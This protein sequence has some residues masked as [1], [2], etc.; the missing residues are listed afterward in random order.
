MWAGD[1]IIRT[2]LL[3]TIFKTD[4]CSSNP[5]VNGGTCNSAA[6][7]YWCDCPVG[8]T[9]TSCDQGL[10]FLWNKHIIH[11][12]CH[13][14]YVIVN[15]ATGMRRIHAASSH[16]LKRRKAFFVFVPE[17]VCV[18]ND[19]CNN[20]ATC[21]EA[22]D[23]ATATCSCLPGYTESL[24]ETRAFIK[25]LCFFI[26]GPSRLFCTYTVHCVQTGTCIVKSGF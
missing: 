15:A 24:C 6:N 26:V 18:L 9:G 21:R 17:L 4:L 16:R 20:N 5:C 11:Q 3:K 12:S 25:F 19:P 2:I 22:H 8:Y 10:N 13:A 7:G 23:S 14:T 1:P